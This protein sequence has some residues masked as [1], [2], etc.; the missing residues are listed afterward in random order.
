MGKR[1]SFEREP[2]DYYRTVDPRAV[3]PLLRFLKPGTKYLELFAGRGDLIKQ[4]SS[5]GM[6][7]ELATDIEPQARGIMRAD[8]FKLKPKGKLII[9]NPPWT[10]EILHK[11]IEHFVQENDLWLLFDAAWPQTKQSVEILDRY[12]T[13]IAAVGRLK[14]FEKGDHREKGHD[15]MD[16]CSWYRF[17]RNKTGATR[18]WGRIECPRM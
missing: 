7:C 16:D 13:D 9:S 6:V 8:A 10:R 14:W 12:C 18:F 3:P 17:S 1:S 15:P 2:R 5:A 11:I 4:L